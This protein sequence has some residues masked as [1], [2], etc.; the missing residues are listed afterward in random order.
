M[1]VVFAGPSIHGAPFDARGLELRGPAAQGD[2]TLATKQGARVIGLIDGAFSSVAAV[3]HKEILF[4]LSQGVAV[5]GAASMGALRAAECAAFGMIP[6]GLIAHAYLAGELDDDGAV[7]LTMGPAAL[8]WPATTEPLVD[9]W[10]TADH[11]V[12]MGILTREQGTRLTAAA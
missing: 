9:V 5:Y 10:A 2:L 12:S 4:A 8:G 6:V 7:A 11:L 1:K 3:W